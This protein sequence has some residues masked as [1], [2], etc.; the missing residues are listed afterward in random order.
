M[1]FCR[2]ARGAKSVA[3]FGLCVAALSLAHPAA[4]RAEW[5]HHHHYTHI[6]DTA[7]PVEIAAASAGFGPTS[8]GASSIVINA[9]TGQVLEADAADVPRYP[10]SLTKL[11]TLDL[12]F[13]ALRAGRITLDT[14]IPVSEHAASVEPV[15]LGLQAGR[16]PRRAPGDFGDDHHVRQRCRHSTWRISG[17]RLRGIAARK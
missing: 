7:A 10:A 15:K 8:P 16:H 11:M 5:R 6:R 9:S 1:R 12:A 2:S 17:R 3:A 4:A 14:E 13:Q